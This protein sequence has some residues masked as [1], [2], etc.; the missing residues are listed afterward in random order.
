MTMRIF[1]N[2]QTKL[3]RDCAPL[4]L[5][6][7]PWAN[8]PIGIVAANQ[9]SSQRIA[10]LLEPDDRNETPHFIPFEDYQPQVLSYGNNYEIKIDQSGFLE[11]SPNRLDHLS[12]IILVDGVRRLMRLAAAHGTRGYRS[13]HFDLETG[14]ITSGAATNDYAIFARWE[15]R[16][17]TEQNEECE[18]LFKFAPPINQ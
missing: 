13:A 1:P 2:L 8:F 12:G 11:L 9:D 14:L 3:L 6:R 10:I 4:E 17:L 5:V 18:P 16:I 15:L 7:Y